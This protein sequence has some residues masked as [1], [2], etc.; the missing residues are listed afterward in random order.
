LGDK[1]RSRIP[2]V[3][4]EVALVRDLALPLSSGSQDLGDPVRLDDV[5][6]SPWRSHSVLSWCFATSSQYQIVKEHPARATTV[7]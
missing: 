4:N 5:V 1:Y 6:V 7:P 2:S 3:R